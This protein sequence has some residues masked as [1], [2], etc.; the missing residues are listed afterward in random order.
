MRSG[1]DRAIVEDHRLLSGDPGREEAW[2][3][4]AWSGR[5]PWFRLPPIQ[6]GRADD[7]R[8]VRRLGELF[9]GAGMVAGH[10]G[11]IAL[12]REA[13][14][15]VAADLYLNAYNHGTLE[16]LAASGVK[17][18]TLSLELEAQEA[19]RVKA[20]A[21]RG[22][23]VEVVVGGAVYSM[24]TRQDFGLREGE[25]LLAVSEHGHAYR[26]SASSAPRGGGT[27]VLYEAREL[28]GAEALSALSGRVDGI[29]LDLAHQASGAV[30]E[31]VAAYR[32]AL[33]EPAVAPR[34]TT[35]GALLAAAIHRR[36]AP[37]GA[38]PGH[39]LRGARSFDRSE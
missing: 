9:P 29:R 24:L 5:Q 11:Q 20:R 2:L 33:S 38:F 8:A 36:H 34:S 30:G 18:V 7:R 28:V 14:L 3:A 19:A 12:A 31:I 16:A 37:A 27:T 15:P 6:H 35:P 22:L 25:E 39:L 4:G 10:L 17:R 13:G 21:P 23:E 1:S 26:F 32:E